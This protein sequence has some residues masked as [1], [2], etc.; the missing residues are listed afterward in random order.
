LAKDGDMRVI[1]MKKDT[2]EL[3][4]MTVSFNNL[5]EKFSDTNKE[6]QYRVFE[7]FVH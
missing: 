4:D 1:D 5:I 3:H 7:L 2:T 6:L